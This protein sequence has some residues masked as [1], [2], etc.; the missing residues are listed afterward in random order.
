MTQSAVKNDRLAIQARCGTLDPS[1]RPE[2]TPRRRLPGLSVSVG[3]YTYP[4]VIT[5]TGQTAVVLE[6]YGYTVIL[7]NLKTRP[8]DGRRRQGDPRSR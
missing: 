3:A 2:S 6:P 7:I 5:V 8:N 4:T 1:A